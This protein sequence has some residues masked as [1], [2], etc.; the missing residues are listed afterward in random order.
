MLMKDKILYSRVVKIFNP[1]SYLKWCLFICGMHMEVRV[2]QFLKYQ[3]L[4]KMNIWC[5]IWFIKCKDFTIYHI[6]TICNDDVKSVVQRF[7][8]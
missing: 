1:N 8:K 3:E 7:T 2:I 5:C 4:V 6:S